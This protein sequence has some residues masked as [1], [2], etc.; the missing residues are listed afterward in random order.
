MNNNEATDKLSP[1][2][3]LTSEQQQLV[4]QVLEFTTNH[5]KEQSTPAIFTIF[6]DAGTGKSVVLSHLFN[7]IQTALSSWLIR[8]V[9][10]IKSFFSR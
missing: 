6:G 7:E 8:E 10:R 3:P 4:H 2:K 1:L 9:G 5:L